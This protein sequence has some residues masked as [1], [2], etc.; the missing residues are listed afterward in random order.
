MTV[1]RT[2]AATKD[3]ATPATMKKDTTSGVEERTTAG[4][5]ATTR[6]PMNLKP[7]VKPATARTTAVTEAPAKSAAKEKKT[8][9]VK[10]TFAQFKRYEAFRRE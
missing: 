8:I 3:P 5:A 9:N 4:A 7:A 1:A 6:A 2:A 10:T